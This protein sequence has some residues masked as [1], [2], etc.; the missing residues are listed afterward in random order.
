MEVKYCVCESIHFVEGALTCSSSHKPATPLIFLCGHG[1]ILYYED[2]DDNAFVIESG[3]YF[4]TLGYI[5]FQ[6]NATSESIKKSS[7]VE[8]AGR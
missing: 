2:L 5:R 3:K 4:E 7:E 6:L 8:E 1:H